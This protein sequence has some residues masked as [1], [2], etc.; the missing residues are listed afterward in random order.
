MPVKRAISEI[1]DQLEKGSSIRGDPE[2]L[3][4]ALVA[5]FHRGFSFHVTSV[6]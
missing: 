6:G 3:K 2:Y 1:K 5:E 4:W